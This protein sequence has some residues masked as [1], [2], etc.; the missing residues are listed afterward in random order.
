[1]IGVNEMLDLIQ[2]W[3]PPDGKVLDV[4]CGR[5][6]MVA[7]L[8]VRD[9]D[10]LGIDPYV[11]DIERCLHLAAEEMDRL[12][13]RFDLVYTRYALHHLDAPRRFPENARS[14]LRPGGILITVDWAAG[15]RTGVREG[16]FSP[17]AV[18]RWMREAGFQVVRAD[19]RDESMV[20]VAKLPP[21]RWRSKR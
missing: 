3:L 13:Q 7:A 21:A 2:T 15:A 20:I 11:R 1:M 18:A 6:R 16:Y 12:T 5:G 8:T 10:V 9:V 14:V 19:E 17:P 4:G